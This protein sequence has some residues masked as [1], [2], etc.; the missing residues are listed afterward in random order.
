MTD[1]TVT[2]DSEEEKV[3]GSTDAHGE[4]R[5]ELLVGTTYSVWVTVGEDETYPV[6][7]LEVNGV[8]TSEDDSPGIGPNYWTVSEGDTAI[9]TVDTHPDDSRQVVPGQTDT[10][11]NVTR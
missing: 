4:T 10:P 1:A 3:T 7:N 2:A 8:N 5:A 11:E 9:V 6:K